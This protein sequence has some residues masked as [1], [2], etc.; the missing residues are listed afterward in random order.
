MK[1]SVPFAAW[2]T[3]SANIW[4]GFSGTLVRFP[5]LA[6]SREA[7]GHGVSG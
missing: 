4:R 3:K 6:V 7:E 2:I 5:P 1:R